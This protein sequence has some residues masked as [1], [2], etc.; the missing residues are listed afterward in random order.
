MAIGG[1]TMSGETLDLVMTNPYAVDAVVWCGSSSE[2]G[3]DSA[4]EIASMLVP[5]GGTVVREQVSRC[6]PLRQSLSVRLDPQRGAVHA[7]LLQTTSVDDIVVEG[8]P[9][10]QDWWIPVLTGS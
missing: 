3:D 7:A 10:A 8:V 1:S 9:L 6:L 4:S 5:A 2:N